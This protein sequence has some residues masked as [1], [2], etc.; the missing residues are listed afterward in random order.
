[1]KEHHKITRNL[2]VYPN[3]TVTV[4]ERVWAHVLHNAGVPEAYKI[5][6]PLPK[7]LLTSGYLNKGKYG[8]SIQGL[9]ASQSEGYSSKW[10]IWLLCL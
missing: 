10:L 3:T 4:A 8:Y 7:I 6:Q 9:I 1:M 2:L 5:M